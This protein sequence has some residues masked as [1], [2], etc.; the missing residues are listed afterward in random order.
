MFHRDL[1]YAL[2]AIIL[3]PDV[4][5]RG[6]GPKKNSNWLKTAKRQMATFHV[7]ENRFST[8]VLFVLNQRDIKKMNIKS[9]IKVVTRKVLK[10]Y[11][12]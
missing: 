10:S 9:D 11:L 7:Y 5:G 6:A 1:F 4:P 2:S 12:K 8:K 3:C